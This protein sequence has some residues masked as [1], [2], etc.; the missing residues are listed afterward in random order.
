MGGRWTGLERSGSHGLRPYSS[1]FPRTGRVAR[2]GGRAKGGRR[3]RAAP[4]QPRLTRPAR[5]RRSPAEGSGDI[6]RL[7]FLLG[8]DAEGPAVMMRGPGVRGA[9]RGVPPTSCRQRGHDQN[10]GVPGSGDRGAARADQAA[11][12][13]AVPTASPPRNGGSTRST[14][15]GEAILHYR[16]VQA[17]QA[18]AQQA[19]AE[20]ALQLRKHCRGD[21]GRLRPPEVAVDRLF[22]LAFPRRVGLQK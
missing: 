7:V 4:A 12:F 18:L 3:Q 16:M 8:D 13:A 10:C 21:V 2:R 9:T 1:A 15:T 5:R 17:A 22:D 14:R 19:L 20:L 11:P 6:P